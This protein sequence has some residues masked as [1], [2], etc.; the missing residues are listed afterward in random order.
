MGPATSPGVIVL[1]LAAAAAV[2]G[3]WWVSIRRDRRRRRLVEWIKAN[4][5]ARWAALPWFSRSLMP[6]SAVE[7][8]RRQGLGNDADFMVRYRESKRG[9]WQLL[10]LI[11]FGVLLIGMVPFGVRY[12]GWNW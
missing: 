3:A 4:H 9:T 6:A 7:H 11:V 5:A 1:T 8:L 2:L 10:S 12:L